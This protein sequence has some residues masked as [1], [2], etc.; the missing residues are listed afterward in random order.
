MRLVLYNL[1][2][3]QLNLKNYEKTFTCLSPCICFHQFKLRAKSNSYNRIFRYLYPNDGQLKDTDGN[4]RP[5]LKYYGSFSDRQM[6]FATDKINHVWYKQGDTASNAP[7]TLGR[8]DMEFE[9]SNAFV[10]IMAAEQQ[11]GYLNFFK[12]HIPNGVVNV[13]TYEKITYQDL[14]TNTDMQVTKK[15]GKVEYKVTFHP[16]ANANTFKLKFTG[17]TNLEVMPDGSL[18]AENHIGKAEFEKPTGEKKNGGQYVPVN[19]TLNKIGTDV[20]TITIANYQA[21]K[22]Y[23]VGLRESK[24][25]GEFTPKPSKGKNHNVHWNTYYGG[26]AI[27]AGANTHVDNAGNIY[28]VGITESSNFPST[29]G[30]VIQ[31]QFAEGGSDAFV[32]KFDKNRKRDWATFYGGEEGDGGLTI[33]VDEQQYV[34]F[35]GYTQS[36]F[37][38]TQDVFDSA[39]YFQPLLNGDGNTGG[40]ASYDAFIVKLTPSGN[41]QIWAT[42][43]GGTGYNVGISLVL[44]ASSIYLVGETGANP[45]PSVTSTG[46]V[47]AG[48]N[49]GQDGL[50]AKFNKTT[51]ALQWSTY[52]GGEGDEMIHDCVID[53]S[54]NLV[55]TGITASA[56]ASSCLP[57]AGTFPLCNPG[58]SAFV[59]GNHGYEDAFIAKFNSSNDLLW[60][61]EFGGSLTESQLD[62]QGFFSLATDASG[63]I[64][65]AGT[66]WSSDFYP[67]V[68][69]LDNY[70]QFFKGGCDGFLAK[71][72]NTGER[73][74]ATCYGGTDFDAISDITI[75]SNGEIFFAGFTS[76]TDFPLKV[77]GRSYNQFNLNQGGT[78]FYYDGFIAWLNKDLRQLWSTYFGGTADDKCAGIAVNLSANALVTVGYTRSSQAQQFP[79]RDIP[80]TIDY[81]DGGINGNYDAFIADFTIGCHPCARLADNSGENKSLAFS[82]NP[83]LLVY[84]N[85][86]NSALHLQDA[87]NTSIKIYNIFGELV[88]SGNSDSDLKTIDLSSFAKGLYVLQTDN[89][90]GQ[91][92]QRIIIE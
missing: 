91:T 59:E 29:E 90:L 1:L 76:S 54:N 74:W 47:Q 65:L 45:I 71:F 82:E 73:V 80:G 43:F 27:D 32:L 46:Y 34:Y 12:E 41:T 62:A 37:F 30:I 18:K 58:G 92:N 56:G 31:D 68:T 23:V 2:S 44:S 75:D 87:E 77:R 83:G 36:I 57:V 61:T 38:P 78:G 4:P 26:S 84:P 6:Y 3:N 79:L 42:Y 9:N 66:T 85:P 14:Y 19:V 28:V 86:A 24:A 17:T 53:N 70:Y 72:L 64:Y 50:I 63:S 81:Y 35:T 67:Y 5:E 8:M 21:N 25:P 69:D 15:E 55:I 51:Y 11:Q 88:Y 39:D 7:D 10:Q 49:G 22:E 16:G 40:Y 48:S 89:S 13:P 20:I 60:S 33:A 52:F